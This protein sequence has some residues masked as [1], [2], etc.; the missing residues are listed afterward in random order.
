MEKHFEALRDEEEQ[1][2]TTRQ[3]ALESTGDKNVRREMKER[4][5]A[6]RAQ[7]K[8]RRKAAARSLYNTR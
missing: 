8:D 4:I 3:H 6:I 2:L 7:F 5:R 1:V